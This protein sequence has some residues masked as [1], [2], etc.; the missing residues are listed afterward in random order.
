MPL[1]ALPLTLA[2]YCSFVTAALYFYQPGVDRKALVQWLNDNVFG[3]NY[4]FAVWGVFACHKIMEWGCLGIYT[5]LYKLELPLFER[6]RAMPHK[7][8]PWKDPRPEVREEA[9]QLRSRAFWYIVKF[10]FCVALFTMYLGTTIDPK[11][12]QPVYLASETPEWYTSMWQVLVA[13]IIAETGFYWGHRILHTK[14]LYWA[15]KRHHE[16]KDSTVWATFYVSFLDFFI[17]DFIPAG[18]PIVFLDMHIYTIYMYTIPL[19]LNAVWVHCGYALPLRFNPLLALPMSTQSEAMHDVHHRTSKHNFG[20]AYFVMDR[21]FG[22]Y[23]NPDELAPSSGSP[24]S[25]DPKGKFRAEVL[26]E[27][28]QPKSTDIKE[29]KAE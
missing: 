11:T 26:A 2:D 14:W 6:N 3:N 16:F 9:K 12:P 8:W 21:I 10:H 22:T 20:G 19:I 1:H 13:T 15:H 17:T 7:P 5:L 24:W 29:S 4:N 27:Q 18:L 23:L 28:A 25:I